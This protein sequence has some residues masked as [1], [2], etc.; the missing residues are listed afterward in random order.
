[1]KKRSCIISDESGFFLPYVLF[2][3]ALVFI[4]ITANIRTYQHEIEITYH[5]I[6]RVKAETII[7]MGLAKFKERELPT[8]LETLHIDY[9][10]P[11]GEVTLIYSL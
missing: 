8:E 2:I 4:I 9:L 1:M 6:E 10:F 3:V 7:Q 5:H 11:D